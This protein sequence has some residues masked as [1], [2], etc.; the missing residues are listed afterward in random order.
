MITELL[1][2]G[3]LLIIKTD[4]TLEY[5]SP[6]KKKFSLD[7]LQAAVKIPEYGDEKF[8]ELAPVRVKGHQV[9]VNESGLLIGMP[10]NGYAEQLLLGCEGVRLYAGNVV[11][12]PNKLWG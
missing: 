12:V 8:I 3:Q 5:V 7:E 11:I 10:L 2:P 9:I 1:R 6:S 4:G